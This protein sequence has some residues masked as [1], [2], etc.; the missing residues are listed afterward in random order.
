MHENQL[1]IRMQFQDQENHENLCIPRH[2]HENHENL[3]IQ[4]QSNENH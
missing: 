2:N 4:R 3:K 1:I